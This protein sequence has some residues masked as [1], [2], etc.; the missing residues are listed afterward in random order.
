MKKAALDVGDVRIGIAISDASETIASGY[1]T[2]IRVNDVVKDA[3]YIDEFCKKNEVDAIVAGLP[4]RTDGTRGKQA[5]KT[6]EFLEE[7]ATIT[8]C[9][10]EYLDER[11]TSSQAEKLLIQSGVRRD[12]RKT[13]IDKVAATIILQCYLDKIN[14]K[15]LEDQNKC[16]NN[17]DNDNVEDEFVDLLTIEN[18]GKET[19]YEIL[20]EINL[21]DE[22]YLVLS[23]YDEKVNYKKNLKNLRYC[24]KEILGNGE[25]D[26][27]LIN[28]E[29]TIN[30]LKLHK[31]NC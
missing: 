9:R 10:I 2:Y 4:L 17:N 29:I 11:F 19:T 31:K 6:V 3:K 14:S 22:I 8:S 5:Y 15:K 23:E 20:Y 7:L 16:E 30:K 26:Y 12:K 1:E 28:D 18:H 24:K 13:V 27:F 21:D 25:E